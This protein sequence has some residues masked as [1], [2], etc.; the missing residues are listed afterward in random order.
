VI[1]IMLKQTLKFTLLTGLSIGLNSCGLFQAPP[2]PTPSKITHNL[3]QSTS[4]TI[5]Y[6]INLVPMDVPN[7]SQPKIVNTAAFR[8]TQN[9]LSGLNSA[10][11]IKQDYIVTGVYSNDGTTCQIS[12]QGIY[13]DYASLEKNHGD[14]GAGELLNNNSCNPKLGIPPGQL[15]QI[16]F[17]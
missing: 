14:L 16:I 7:P 15:M 13:P 10:V 11:I 4:G 12:W 6:A 1:K 2:P 9:V 5:I 3:S 8:V 17:K